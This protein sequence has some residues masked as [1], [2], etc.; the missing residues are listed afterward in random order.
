MK[1]FVKNFNN[2]V[3]KTI[4][5]VENKTNNKLKISSFNK[6]LIT[7]IGLL[8]LYVFYLLI[9]TIYDKDWVKDNIQ[10]KLLREFKLNLN[11]IEDIS[12]RILPAPHFLIKDSNLR[13]NNPS[14]EKSIAEIRDLKIFLS[15]LNFFN[16]EKMVIKKVIINNANFSLLQNDLKELNNSTN[17]KFSNKEIKVNKSNLFF[18]DNLGEIISI[19]KV[20]KANLFFDDKKLE[21]QFNLKGN[22]FAIPFTFELKIKNDLTIVKNFLFKAKSLRLDIFNSSIKKKDNSAIGNSIIYFLRSKIDTEYKLIDESIIFKSKDSKIRNYKIKYDGEISINPFDLNLN[23]SLNNNKI[24]RLFNLN[25]TLIEFFKSG[26]LFNDNINLNTT[27]TINSKTGENLFDDAE[28]YFN[29]RNGK[30]NF[31]NTKFTNKKIGSLELNDSSLFLDN[32]RLVLNM[33][34]FFNISNSA[35]LF[36]FLNTKK[37][38]R[39][40]IKNVLVNID[41]DFSSNEIKFNKIKINK[42][43]LNN[44]EML[45]LE[46]F[47][48]N[49]S[50]NLIKTRRLLNELFSVYA[51]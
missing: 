21:N 33:N 38:S 45:V 32:N 16:K 8:F 36:S 7:F 24:S 27:I 28:I 51:G 12:Y 46:G 34:L 9:P 26:L 49:Y 4:F 18:K 48:D 19:I 11:F 43:E 50:N 3:K 40:E 37:E 23:I 14:S 35:H 25:P 15:Q 13:S 47:N 6:T 20:D 5:K 30:I 42:N 2:L 22:I 31:N 1:Q 44:Q 10:T 29:I 39:K 17:R 41:Y